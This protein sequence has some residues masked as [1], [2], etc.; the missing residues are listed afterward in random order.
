MQEVV[1]N[2]PRVAFVQ[3][4]S[5]LHY[6]V[7]LALQ[8]AGM[9]DRVYV[10]WYS[11]KRSPERWV[12]KVVGMVK[13]DLG[14]RMLHRRCEGLDEAKVVRRST[15]TLLMIHRRAR[16]SLEGRFDKL[17]KGMEKF[18]RIAS[19]KGYG[20][21]NVLM[22]F[23][24]EHHPLLFE[25]ARARGMT[26]VADQ[27]I[28]PAAI[29]HEE[30]TEQFRRWPDWQRAEW[31][32][33]LP[34]VAEVERR[35]W[36]ALDHITCASDYVK[37]GL[38]REGVAAERVSVLPYPLDVKGFA[39]TDRRPGP[40]AS[41][42]PVTVGFVGHVHLRKGAP[43]FCEVAKR[44]RGRGIQFV[45]VGPVY[46]EQS[47]VDAHRDVVEIVGA[48]PRPQVA[49]WLRKFDVLLFPSTCEGSSSA[50]T[51]A[52][53]SGLPV[54]CSPNSGSVVRHGTDGYIT[55][56]DNVEAMAGYVERLA[57]DAQLRHDMGLSA[58]LRAAEFTV[59]RYSR[60]IAGLLTR[61]MAER[62]GRAAPVAPA[63]PPA[64]PVRLAV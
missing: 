15:I 47:V 43:Y 34:Q 58:S 59:D 50:V 41:P 29:E 31:F 1:N 16:Q 19:A 44:L 26:T 64:E 39:F 4:G 38:L 54:V 42:R 17:L 46:I 18:A 22:A 30:M 52:M 23:L 40:A 33:Y 8:R 35:C 48:V 2:Q 51:E 56:Y 63:V 12:S 21:A 9:L 55:P 32:D 3:I 20:D 14:R 27:I 37:Q 62:G 11:G 10:D 25:S 49:D 5:R 28:A 6:A 7:P 36:A 53:A 45:M 61:L 24:R 57:A 60:E 13:P